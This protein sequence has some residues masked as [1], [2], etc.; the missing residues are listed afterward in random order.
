[1]WVSVEFNIRWHFEVLLCFSRSD[2]HK[3]LCVTQHVSVVLP[4]EHHRK[5]CLIVS[6]FEEGTILL[7]KMSCRFIQ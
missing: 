1:M 4:V 3:I 6:S 5:L 2:F 7:L